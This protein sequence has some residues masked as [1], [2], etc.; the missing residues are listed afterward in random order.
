MS[1]VQ[2][3]YHG[4]KDVADVPVVQL[5]C[6]LQL[7]GRQPSERREDDPYTPNASLALPCKKGILDSQHLYMME[8]ELAEVEERVE[9][10]KW[11][12]GAWKKVMKASCNIKVTVRRI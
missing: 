2:R 4:D 8:E 7:C 3:E 9:K 5:D 10:L 6:A 1:L 12:I 11:D